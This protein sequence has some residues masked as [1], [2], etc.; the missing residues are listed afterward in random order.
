MADL[1]TLN[2]IFSFFPGLHSDLLIFSFD[3]D[4]DSQSHLLILISLCKGEFVEQQ[5]GVSRE[6]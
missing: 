4:S 5:H 3:P 6:R 1:L 2:L